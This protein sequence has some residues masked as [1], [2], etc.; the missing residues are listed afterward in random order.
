MLHYQ[1]GRSRFAYWRVKTL[2]AAADTQPEYLE[3]ETWKEVDRVMTER[4][5]QAFQTQFP[6]PE[7]R[8]KQ[9]LEELAK[10]RDNPMDKR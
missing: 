10:K 6:T 9:F 5:G 7:D 3:L 1:P 8:G 4:Y 2:A